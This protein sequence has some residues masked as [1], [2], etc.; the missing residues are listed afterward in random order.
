MTFEEANERRSNPNLEKGIEYQRNCQCCVASHELR[1]RGF[2]VEAVAINESDKESLACQLA[3]RTHMFWIDPE[4]NKPLRIRDRVYNVY[5]FNAL[6]EKVKEDGRYHLRFPYTRG[7]GHI[8]TFE[9]KNGELYF[10]DPQI[11]KKY[12]LQE[13]NERYDSGNV[14]QIQHSYVEFYRVDDLIVNLDYIGAVK[15]K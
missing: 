6:S 8:M 13:L 9:R 7:N 5:D 11:G 1:M 12:T 15:K 14:T 2:D 3:K 4:T 10:Y